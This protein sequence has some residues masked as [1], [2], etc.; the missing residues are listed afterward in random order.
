VRGPVASYYLRMPT[1]LS[2]GL[3]LSGASVLLGQTTFYDN[4]SPLLQ[5][6]CQQCHTPNNIAQMC[7]AF[8]GVILDNDKVA[9]LL[10]R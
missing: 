3:F 6:K 1:L 9:S 5:T 7:L 8:I 2:F 10:F 4:I